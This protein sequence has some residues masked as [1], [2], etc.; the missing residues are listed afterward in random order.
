VKSHRDV[1]DRAGRGDGDWLGQRLLQAGRRGARNRRR[2]RSCDS[3]PVNASAP[4]RSRRTRPHGGTGRCRRCARRI[5]GIY[6][7]RQV[8]IVDAKGRSVSHTG[9]K[10]F[11]WAGHRT[12]PDFAIQGNLLVSEQTVI[13]M[14]RAFTETRGRL[15]ERMIRA[16]EEGQN[17]GGDSRGMQSAAL[18]IVK[19][20]AGYAGTDRYCDLRVDDHAEPIRELRRLF[21][22]WRVRAMT[23]EGY[24]LLETKEFTRAIALGDE[25]VALDSSGESH[26]NSACFLARA[27]RVKEALGRL[28]EA[29]ARNPSWRPE[30]PRIPTSSLF[31]R[32]MRSNRWSVNSCRKVPTDARSWS[33]PQE[34][35][36]G[37]VWCTGF[38]ETSMTS[39]TSNRS[40]TAAQLC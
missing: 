36:G 14:E 9:S 11:A 16:L 35:D 27:G 26:F 19:K 3:H 17:A 10:A 15:G 1:F 34:P 22:I 24:R 21:T 5:R 32:L 38:T 28:Q 37:N 6:P 39:H 20:G 4:A 18:L 8:G 33:H 2:C 12:G 31:A 30:R 23:M 13:A 25:A 40:R 29:I 7:H